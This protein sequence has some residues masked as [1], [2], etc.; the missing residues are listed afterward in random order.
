[1][2]NVAAAAAKPSM[3]VCLTGFRD[4][5]LEK[6]AQERGFE[7]APSVT[8]TLHVLITP[9]GDRTES[10]KVKKAVKYGTVEILSRSE[11]LNKYINND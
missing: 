10:E 7:I 4:K 9:D 8:Q 6:A 1:M 3:R 11:F 2:T 5:E